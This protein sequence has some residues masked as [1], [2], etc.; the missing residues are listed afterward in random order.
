LL[1]QRVLG[2]PVLPPRKDRP[3]VG[4]WVLRW[5][6]SDYFLNLDPDG[7]S[8]WA[9]MRP[10]ALVGYPSD[11]RYCKSGK[12]AWD[13]KTRTLTVTDPHTNADLPPDVW[14]VTF[15]P[16]THWSG[17]GRCLTGYPPGGY[18][19]PVAMTRASPDVLSKITT[20]EPL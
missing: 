11:G 1:T 20:R 17:T 19:C 2:A 7:N 5:N 18:T 13:R 8:C 3:P 4:S 9:L 10:E 14:Q 15:D 12:W 6:Q 16:V